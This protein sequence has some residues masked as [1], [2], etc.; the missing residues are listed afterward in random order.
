M[1]IKEKDNDSLID[2]DRVLINKNPK[3]HKMLPSFVINYLKKIAHQEDFN[4]LIRTYKNS[5][6]LDFVKDVL[7]DAKISTESTGQDNIPKE[8]KFILAANH[9]IGGIDGLAFMQ[10]TGK[11]FGPTKSIINDLL[12]NI[13]NLAPLFVGVN[14]HGSASRSVFKEIDKTFLSDEQILIFPAGLASRRTKGVIRD[15]EWKKTFITKAVKYERDIIP[16]HITGKLSNFFYNFANIRKFLG[17]KSNLEM[18]YLA[19]E[20]FKQKNRTFKITFGKP[21]SYKTFDKSK[22]HYEW[23]QEVKNHVYLL[24]DNQNEEFKFNQLSVK[25]E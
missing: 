16:V 8:G 24:K 13:K 17:I 6:G 15:L 9:P 22:T 2:I 18:L 7:A 5:I 25:N 11:I 14:K 4:Y 10:E 3:L 23:A 20:T 21:I 1:S 19:D 12:L